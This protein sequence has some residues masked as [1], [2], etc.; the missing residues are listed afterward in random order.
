VPTQFAV[1]LSSSEGESLQV[2]CTDGNATFDPP[3]AARWSPACPAGG[4][5]LQDFTPDELSVSVRWSDGEATQIFRPT[6]VASRPN[7][8][9][10]DPACQSA[11]L[12]LH[13]PVVPAYGDVATWETYVDEAHGFSLRYPP[14]LA[15]EFG[16]T[17]DGYG[18]VYF[19]EKIQLRTSPGDPLVC[20][21]DCP[22]LESTQAV[23][24]AGRGAQ[25]VHGYIG[26]VGG[27]IPQRFMLYLLRS[28]STYV[29]L[30]LFA[31]DR[32]D[33]LTTDPSAILPL[34]EADIE[35]FNR[36]VQTLEWIP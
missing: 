10:C 32:H 31:A 5:T 21:G 27:S 35:L 20:Q 22:M 15:P 34:Q 8:P 14:E 16:P 30:V 9:D 1:S 6:Y 2:L 33:T 11:T 4:V 17:V 13:I 3:E 29:A 24:I 26:S 7:G 19:G 25:L 23:T 28:G 36:M 18:T 12:D